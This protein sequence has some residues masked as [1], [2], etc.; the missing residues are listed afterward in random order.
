MGWILLAAV[1]CGTRS[2]LSKSG[3][4]G[5]NKDI[6]AGADRFV[7]ADAFEVATG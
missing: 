6:S 5:V 7:L 3:D 1:G 2:T 4:A